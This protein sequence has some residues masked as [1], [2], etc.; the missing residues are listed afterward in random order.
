[1]KDVN[2]RFIAFYDELKSRKVIA[3][4]GQFATLLGVSGSLITEIKGNRSSPGLSILQNAVSKFPELNLSWLLTGKGTMFNEKSSITPTAMPDDKGIN[5]GDFSSTPTSESVLKS[6]LVHPTFLKSVHPTVHPTRNLG[7]PMVVVT[8]AK[9]NENVVFVPV[10][11]R[12]GYLIG[13]GDLDFIQELPTYRLPG[14][15]EATHRAFEVEGHSMVPTLHAHDIVVG[16]WVESL[17]HIRDDRVYILVTK[18]G[19]LV[20]R[21]L[22]R[23]EK[24]GFIL[25]KSDTVHNRDQYPALQISPDQVLECWYARMYL[26]SDFRAPTEVYHRINDLEAEVAAIKKRLD[27]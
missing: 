5:K 24:H 11:A 22:N 18:E 26:S 23:I 25:A 8:D 12:A 10:R 2:A 17:D 1:M 20:K 6:N 13:Y 14:L 21:V 27:V 4:Q 9:G 16:E 7:L 19:I 15:A 3:N